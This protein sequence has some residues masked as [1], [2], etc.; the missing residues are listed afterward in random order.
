MSCKDWFAINGLLSL[1]ISPAWRESDE[2]CYNTKWQF[3]TEIEKYKFEHTTSNHTKNKSTKRSFR[4]MCN[5]SV[6]ASFIGILV[7]AHY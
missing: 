3:A 5:F 4:S 2:K 1:N 7:K 6:S